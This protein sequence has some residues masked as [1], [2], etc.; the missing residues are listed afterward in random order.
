MRGGSRLSSMGLN[1]GRELRV[2]LILLMSGK[3]GVED[4]AENEA[5]SC[6]SRGHECV[7]I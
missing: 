2:M 6:R 5:R 3:R 7:G 1:E 4:V